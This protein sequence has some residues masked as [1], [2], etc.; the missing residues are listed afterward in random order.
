MQ[1][2]GARALAGD[3]HFIYLCMARYTHSS[4]I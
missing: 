4:V 1:T 2:M 3:R